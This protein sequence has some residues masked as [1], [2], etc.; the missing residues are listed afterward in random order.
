[1]D[2]VDIPVVAREAERE[3]LERLLHSEYARVVSERCLIFSPRVG[4]LS[5]L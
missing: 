5:R 3:I 4:I 1:M 2:W